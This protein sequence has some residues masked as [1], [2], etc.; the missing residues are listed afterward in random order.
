MSINITGCFVKETSLLP[1]TTTTTYQDCYGDQ[2]W[3]P[4]NNTTTY[5]SWSAVTTTTTHQTAIYTNIEP[6]QPPPAGDRLLSTPTSSETSHHPQET[7]VDYLWPQLPP[8][9]TTK[10]TGD[11]HHYLHDLTTSNHHRYV[12]DNNLHQHRL[13]LATTRRSR[14]S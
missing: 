14:I 2:S 6:D 13:G 11:H 4:T 5:Q 9:R 3:L 7:R 10:E 8:T 12:P 1:V